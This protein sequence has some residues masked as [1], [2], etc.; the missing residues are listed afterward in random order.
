MA[1]EIT[2]PRLAGLARA[3]EAGEPGALDAFWGGIAEH[4]T[5]LVEPVAG[6]DGHVQ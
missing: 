2:S 6:D 1:E 4:G 5:P 3:L